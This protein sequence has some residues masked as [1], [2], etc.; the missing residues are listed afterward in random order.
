MEIKSFVQLIYREG[1]EKKRSFRNR[2]KRGALL[3]SHL[4][5][6]PLFFDS[7]S[8]FLGSDMGTHRFVEITVLT[9]EVIGTQLKGDHASGHPDAAVLCI[10]RVGIL[11]F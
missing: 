5:T 10:V 2:L 8:N 7:G 11:Y 1:K 4:S 9:V 6:R 3:R